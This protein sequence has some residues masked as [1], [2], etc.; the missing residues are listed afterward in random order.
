ME[1]SK[2]QNGALVY[3]LYQEEEDETV[4]KTVCKVKGYDPFNNFMWVESQKG[5]EDFISFEP[6]PL[7]EEWLLKCGFEKDE[8]IVFYRKDET[9]STFI[10]DFNFVCLLG[11]SHVK[12]HS[13]HQ[14]Q[15][16]YFALTGEELQITT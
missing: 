9:S 15:N 11:Y 3:G 14:L 10:I 16:L 7:T 6:I 5:I 12:I 1:I 8:I 4:Y 2:L 13:A